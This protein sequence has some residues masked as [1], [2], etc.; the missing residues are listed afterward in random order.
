MPDI[1]I[2]KSYYIPK[3]EK[4]NEDYKIL[5]WE[6]RE[7]QLKRFEILTSHVD[8]NGKKLLDVG[9][10]LGNLLEFLESNNINVDYTGVDILEEM[11]TLAKQKNPGGKFYF[12]DIFSESFFNEGSFDIVYSSGIFNLK[13]SD[14]MGFLKKALKTFFTLSKDMVVFNLLYY[15]SRDKEDMY[16]YYSEGDIDKGLAEISICPQEIKYVRNYL[17]NDLTVICKA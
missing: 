13:I 11:I 15:K 9:C 17:S 7:A 16:Y 10:G 8:L 3:I 12:M 4:Y 2:I 6:S 1:E 14:N 5:G